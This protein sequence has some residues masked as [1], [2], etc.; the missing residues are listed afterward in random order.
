MPADCAVV[1]D[2]SSLGTCSVRSWREHG[3]QWPAEG[4]QLFVQALPLQ[5]GSRGSHPGPG[6]LPQCPCT[7][8][9]GSELALLLIKS[10]AQLTH[11]N[12]TTKAI[13]VHPTHRRKGMCYTD[14]SVCSTKAFG[15][16]AL[17]LLLPAVTKNK[18]S[19]SS[20]R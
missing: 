7:L 10:S 3:W 4:R 1:V 2:S 18:S 13:K 5:K 6:S 15:G 19:H 16:M 9:S 17:A 14:T 12:G 8:P 11:I 20:A